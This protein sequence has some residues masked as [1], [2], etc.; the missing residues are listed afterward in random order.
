MP[1]LSIAERFLLCRKRMRLTQVELAKILRVSRKT[2]S[3]VETG[4]KILDST[5][6]RFYILEK[7]QNGIRREARHTPAHGRMAGTSSVATQPR[8]DPGND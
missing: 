2:V 8:S 1:R 5:V 6:E 7:R 4:G 3:T